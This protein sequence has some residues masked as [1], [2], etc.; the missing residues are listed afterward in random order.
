MLSL[1]NVICKSKPAAV[2]YCTC[3]ATVPLMKVTRAA[4]R[5][6]TCTATVPLISKPAGCPSRW[7]AGHRPGH[8]GKFGV[9]NVSVLGSVETL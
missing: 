7:V 9:A 6:C 4:V 1:I 8:S 3:T 2:R 5:Y